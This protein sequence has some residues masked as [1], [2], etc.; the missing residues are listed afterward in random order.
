MKATTVAVSGINSVDNPGAGIGIIRSLKEAYPRCRCIGLAYD[1]MDPGLYLD[2]YVDKGFLLPYPSVS[3]ER[4]LE[5]LLYICEEHDIDVVI[6]AFDSEL[7]H[8]IKNREEFKSRNIGLLLPSWEQYTK[9]NKSN[10]PKLGERLEIKVPRTHPVS[11]I[12]ELNASLDDVG[13]PA[14]IK[15]CFYEAYRAESYGDAHSLFN[16]VSQKWGLPVLVQQFVSGDDY[17]LIGLGSGTGRLLGAVAA[18][19]L[20]LT[21]MGKIWTAVTIDN[22]A[23]LEICRSFMEATK[24]SGGF[25][26]EFRITKSEEIYLLEINPRFPAWVY[27]AAAA[28]VNL[29]QR[30]LEHLRDGSEEFPNE[31]QVGKLLI[32]YTGEMIKDISDFEGIVVKGEKQ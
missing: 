24:F 6:P 5:R 2:Q 30:Y 18:K 17:N 9:C 23:M 29:P 7:P 16:K 27:L 19:K 28:G 8:Y 31:Y 10:L 32:R 25:E 20:L 26:L 14:M 22:P 4:Y 3:S 12:E 13:F 15:G 21:Q 1:A 11:T